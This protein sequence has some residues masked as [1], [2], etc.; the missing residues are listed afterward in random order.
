MYA[1]AK[2]NAKYRQYSV[3]VIAMMKKIM[4]GFIESC[5]YHW[6]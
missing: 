2:I 5:H 4:L 1:I 3:K 6:M